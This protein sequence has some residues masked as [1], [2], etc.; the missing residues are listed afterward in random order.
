MMNTPRDRRLRRLFAGGI[1]AAAAVLGAPAVAAEPGFGD[2][3][4]DPT[5]PMSPMAP[6]NDGMGDP[7][8]PF[9]VGN[10]PQAPNDIGCIAQ[11]GMGVCEGGPYDPLP[12]GGLTIPGMPS[13]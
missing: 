4:G 13:F 11:P 9:D 1:L 7:T 6:G 8:N 3:I 2:D 10:I 12:Q 5:N